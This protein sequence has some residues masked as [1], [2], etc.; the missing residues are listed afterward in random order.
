LKLAKEIKIPAEVLT[1]K[2][3]VDTAQLGLELTE[4]LQQMA[5]VDD[6]AM[7]ASQEEAGYSKAPVASEAPEGNSNSH[8]AEIV[9]IESSTSSETRSSSASLSSSSSISSD[10]HDICYTLILDLKILV[11]F[12]LLSSDT[13]KF[14]VFSTVLQTH[15]VLLLSPILLHSNPSKVFS[16]IT[17]HLKGSL[18]PLH[19]FLHFIPIFA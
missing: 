13:L 16:C 17:S 4:N 12:S 3:I 1:K 15:I 7:E 8:I 5:V 10:L 19:I 18:R 6:M 14:T 2:S 9:T 11:Q